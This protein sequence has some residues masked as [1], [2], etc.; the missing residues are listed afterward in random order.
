V[1]ISLLD[2]VF[3]TACIVCG[4]KPKPL[5]VACIPKPSLTYVPGFDFPVLAAMPYEDAIEKIIVGYKDQQLVSLAAPLAELV[6]ALIREID[7]ANFSA[8]IT[9]ARNARNF[10]KRGFD[11][12]NRLIRQAIRKLPTS[13]E[14]HSLKSTRKAEDQRRLGKAD[15]EANVAN[16]MRLTA[17]LEG[18]VL[19]FDDVLTTGSTIR[20]MA[21]ACS[22]SGVEVAACC[23][24]AQR[25]RTF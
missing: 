19:L 24:L 14:I 10:R 4:T 16:S 21:R 6:T 9:P 5:C 15:R 20:E 1:P 2:V 3:P 7:V 11:P 8:V 22:S 17:K 12:A 18:P 25:I 13:I 23:V